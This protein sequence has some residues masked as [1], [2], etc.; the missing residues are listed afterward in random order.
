MQTSA[1][2][3]SSVHLSEISLGKN[4]LFYFIF[5]VVMPRGLAAGACNVGRC[6]GCQW[7]R[8]FNTQQRLAAIQLK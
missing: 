2:H 7:L 3:C 5:P 1:M 4:I 8:F 6:P